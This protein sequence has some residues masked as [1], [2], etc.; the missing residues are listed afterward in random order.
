M[1]T[2]VIDHRELAEATANTREPFGNL[3]ITRI[4]SEQEE[5]GYEKIGDLLVVKYEENEDGRINLNPALSYNGIE[6]LP[7]IYGVIM[8]IHGAAQIRLGKTLIKASVVV[9]APNGIYYNEACRGGRVFKH[10]LQGLV[11]TLT[12]DTYSAV[13]NETLEILNRRF[14]SRGH[15]IV[16]PDSY[17]V[18]FEVDGKFVY[19]PLQRVFN[20]PTVAS[21]FSSKITEREWVEKNNAVS[22]LFKEVA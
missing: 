15:G 19:Q 10:E 8:K 7:R 17:L 21:S 12:G 18:R 13:N 14:V 9:N 22:K 6:S 20:N 11:F 16:I 1:Y 3:F 2:I 5:V 4:E